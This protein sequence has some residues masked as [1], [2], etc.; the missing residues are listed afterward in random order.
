M[1]ESLILFKVISFIV[2]NKTSEDIV[3]KIA[4]VQ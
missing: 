3:I 1:L 4:K 2:E